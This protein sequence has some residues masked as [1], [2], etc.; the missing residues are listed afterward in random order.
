MA[1]KLEKKIAVHVVKPGD[2]LWEDC[3]QTEYQV[4]VDSQYI[5][6]NSQKRMV[7]YDPYTPVEFLCA[8]VGDEIA[9]T[10]RIIYAPNHSKMT[11][12]LF[13]TIDAH[14]KLRFLPGKLDQC[15][16]M[17]P[18]QC[19]DIAA[20][21]T[22]PKFRDNAKATCQLTSQTQRRAAGYSQCGQ[23]ATKTDR[24]A[25]ALTGTLQTVDCPHRMLVVRSDV[26]RRL[27]ESQGLSCF[28]W[29]KTWG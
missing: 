1:W 5:P 10:M 23:T 17:D 22:V 24:T 27:P 21:V 11:F 19:I 25:N 13:P 28:S 26:V 16:A 2:A 15:M 3:L 12:G 18:R 8:T 7:A 29:Q 4:F 6:E 9:G 20:M 14:E